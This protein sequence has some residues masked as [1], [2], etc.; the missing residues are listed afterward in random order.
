MP[1]DGTKNRY[2]DELPHL[3]GIRGDEPLHIPTA[4]EYFA[5]TGRVLIAEDVNHYAADSPFSLSDGPPPAVLGTFTWSGF[6]ADNMANIDLSSYFNNAQIANGLPYRAWRVRG[7]WRGGYFLAYYGTSPPSRTPSGVISSIG[8][9][10]TGFNAVSGGWALGFSNEFGNM[11]NEF[12]GGSQLYYFM[13]GP[14]GAPV[15]LWFPIKFQVEVGYGHPNDGTATRLTAGRD[16][17]A[18]TAGVTTDLLQ[19]RGS[20]PSFLCFN[21]W[22]NAPSVIA[23]GGCPNTGQGGYVPPDPPP[24][25]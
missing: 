2:L 16:W 18:F 12:P 23:A 4:D 11:I 9:G 17:P 15:D 3:R 8:Q 21:G 14:P 13:G 5:E 24:D 19:Y 25:L 10:G 20:S 22:A 6:Y 7:L 1:V